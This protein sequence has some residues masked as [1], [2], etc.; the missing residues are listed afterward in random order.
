MLD[1]F[2]AFLAELAASFRWTDAVDIL[3]V[4]AVVYAVLSWLRR[5]AS[6]G[7]PAPRR[8]ARPQAG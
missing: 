7:W 6:R 8:L 4:S 5:A 3:V 2:S 1:V